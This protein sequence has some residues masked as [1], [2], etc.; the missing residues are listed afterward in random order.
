MQATFSGTKITLLGCW[1]SAIIKWCYVLLKW[2]TTGAGYYISPLLRVQAKFHT[3]TKQ[4]VK[5]NH[6]SSQ[7]LVRG[8][9]SSWMWRHYTILQWSFGT[10]CWLHIEG[11][12]RRWGQQFLQKLCNE[13]PPYMTSH[14]RRQHTLNRIVLQSSQFNFQETKGVFLLLIFWWL[15]RSVNFII[16][17]QSV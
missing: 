3:H 9:L 5:L 13:L 15:T 1:V 7:R 2:A 16:Y 17:C 14:L 12:K 6:S 4:R 8:V 10:T 11:R